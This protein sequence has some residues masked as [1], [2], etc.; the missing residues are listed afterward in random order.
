[1]HT[2]LRAVIALVAVG[3]LGLAAATQAVNSKCPIK[4]TPVNPS[5][6]ADY[7]GK[8]IAFC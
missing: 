8:T 7:K 1:M 5:I 3:G 2:S 6:T 4:G